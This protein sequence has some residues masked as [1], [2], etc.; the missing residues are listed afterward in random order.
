MD[1]TIMPSTPSLL[2]R[3]TDDFPDISFTSGE[4]FEWHPS[5]T[6]VVFDHD[7]PYFNAHLL[8]EI[9]HALLKHSTYERDIDLI[10]MERDAWQH[11]RLELAPRY[12]VQ[13]PADILHHDMDTYREWLHARSLCPA[14]GS[15]GIQ[16]KKQEYKCVTCRESWRVNEARTCQLRRYRLT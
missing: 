7:D 11:A 5:D 1:V 8:H 9:A 6:T 14:C 10:A 12:D 2:E 13:I 3:V 15:N 4:L 16:I